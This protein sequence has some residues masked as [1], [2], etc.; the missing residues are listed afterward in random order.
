VSSAIK[1]RV[2]GVYTRGDEILLVNHEKDGRSY[3]L[4]PGGGLEFGETLAAALER[5]LVE[6]CGLKTRSGKLLLLAESLPPDRHRHVLN[7]VFQGEILEGEAHL[8]ELGGDRLKGVAWRK[9]GDLGALTFFPDI[10]DAVLRH[11]DAGFT[12]PAESLGDLWRD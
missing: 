9:K 10:K 6:E 7:L 8:A 5:E 12:L 4:L 11:W 2:A 3:W 1:I